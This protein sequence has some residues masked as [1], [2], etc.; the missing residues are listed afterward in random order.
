MNP[1]ARSLLR[2]KQT[3]TADRAGILAR[4]LMA[5]L[6]EMRAEKWWRG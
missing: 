1:N 4:R 5:W 2:I 6:C 3:L